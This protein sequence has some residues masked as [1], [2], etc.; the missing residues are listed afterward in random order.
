[1]LYPYEFHW[2]INGKL[3]IIDLFYPRTRESAG[4]LQIIRLY[5][6]SNIYPK[7]YM[8]TLAKGVYSYGTREPSF[9]EA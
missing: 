5:K 8:Y 3:F 1:M 9:F 7:I 4:I 2:Y 6:Y